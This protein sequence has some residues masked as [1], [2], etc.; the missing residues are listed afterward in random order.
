MHL[1]TQLLV[2]SLEERLERGS[3]CSPI[4]RRNVNFGPIFLSGNWIGTCNEHLWANLSLLS[5]QVK[6]LSRIGRLSH[7]VCSALVFLNRFIGN[8]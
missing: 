3:Q 6:R 5:S 1:L 8:W 2:D 4:R 7:A